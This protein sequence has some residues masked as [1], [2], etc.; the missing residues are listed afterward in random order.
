MYVY[1]GGTVT[2]GPPRDG[3]H[4]VIP[5]LQAPAE[6]DPKRRQPRQSN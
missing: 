6:A 4:N 2:G 5:E 1:H 3:S